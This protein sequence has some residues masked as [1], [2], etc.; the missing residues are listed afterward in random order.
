MKFIG[1][2]IV[3]WITWFFPGNRE[4]EHAKPE[5]V[6]VIL[7]GA[8]SD[9][10]GQLSP[11][12]EKA[13]LDQLYEALEIGGKILENGGSSLDAVE[14]VIVLME[15]SGIFNSGRGAVFTKE[16]KCELDASIMDGLTGKAG[17]VAG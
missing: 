16:G 1:F 2:F 4:V 6:L 5:W 15:N 11:E 13:Y 12:E 3:S 14:A 9:M 7:G 8:G 17:A 10:E